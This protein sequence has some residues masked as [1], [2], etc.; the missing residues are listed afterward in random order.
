[1]RVSQLSPAVSVGK[2]LNARALLTLTKIST[3][4]K[5]GQNVY[6]MIFVPCV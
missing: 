6:C 4:G 3:I 2:K 5:N 1:M